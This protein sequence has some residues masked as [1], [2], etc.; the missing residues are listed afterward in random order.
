MKFLNEIA[1]GLIATL[2]ANAP[3]PI[4]FEQIAERAG[5][6]FVTNNSPTPDK[7]QPE[8]MV[9]GVAVFDYDGDGYPDVY[10]VNG[11]QM[12]SLRRD[13]LQFE[14][15]L[16]HNNGNLTFTDVTAKAGLGGAGYGM[17][18]AVGDYDNDGRP[19]LYLSSLT[20]NQLFHNNG[21]GT[22][23]DVTARAGVSGGVFEGAKMWSVAAA[24][25]DYNND[26]LLDLFVSNYCKWK[27]GA[28][29]DCR[30]NG[31]RI[32]CSPRYYAPLPNTL[33]RNNGD[34]TFT[35]VSVG[36]GIAGHRGRGMGVA[37]ADY[38]GDG[39]SD[40]FVANDDA[41]NQLFHNLGGK[42][43][44]EVAQDQLVA[45]AEDGKLIS[46]MGVDFRDVF[47]TGKPAIWVTALERQTFPLFAMAASS[48]EDRTAQAGLSAE[49]FG[50]A[51][52]SNAIADL[53][54]DGWKDLAVARSHATDNIALFSDRH[55]E[56]PNS[57]F[58]N[59]GNGHFKNVSATAGTE[60]FAPAAHR[61]L[62]VGDLDNDGK[63]DLVM[64]VLNGK[65]QVYHNVSANQNH[66]LLLKLTG[67]KSN[68][69]GLGAR[70]RLT[71]G[72]GFVQYN[73]A[74]T[75]TGYAC[76]SDPRV[77]FGLGLSNSAREIQITW[78]SGIRQV[79]QNVAADRVV[80][81]TEPAR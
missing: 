41:P 58:R 76:S 36:T 16:Y 14:N 48:F 39:Y 22:F 45:F 29:P 80:S 31:Q 18:V 7:N 37:V 35:D 10:F 71:D 9:A 66:W 54:N 61:G 52:W 74:T 28:D 43:F 19:D 32:Y 55:Y 24:W 59:L 42:R 60:F 21:D 47:N 77:H 33:Y 53:D 8:A 51:G 20:N 12:P 73:H 34:G 13:G 81:V 65:A 15:R 67:T 3:P 64:S 69:M 23:T 56:E 17:G 70:I 49:T 4:R 5:V 6:S 30:V 57:V 62:A 38:D 40:I 26:G 78:P 72:N 50:M 2:T 44:E 25:V 46:G 1:I 63:L 79:L 27:P 75:S 11:G 68:R